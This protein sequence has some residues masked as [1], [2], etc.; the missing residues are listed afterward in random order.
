MITTGFDLIERGANPM[1]MERDIHRAVDKIITTLSTMKEDVDDKKIFQVATVSAHGDEEIGRLVAKAVKM[2]GRDGV[3]TAEPS[4]TSETYVDQVA[5]IELPKSS[6]LH[7]SFITHPEEVKAELTDCRILLWEGVLGS[8]KSLVPLLKQIKDENA[9]VLIVAGGFEAEALSMLINNKIRLALQ[10][11]VVRLEAYGESRKNLLY[12]IAALTGGRV[13]L[14]ADGMKIDNVKLSDLGMARKVVTTMSNTKIIDGKGKQAD[15]TGRVDGLKRAIEESIEGAERTALRR[16][17][18]ALIG[19]ITIIKVGGVTVTEME[20]KKDRVVD[21]MSAAKAAI[22]SGIVA[23][24]GTALFRARVSLNQS[25]GTGFEVVRE[26]CTAVVKQIATNA[27]AEPKEIVKRLDSTMASHSNP[28]FSTL[29]AVGY[30]AYSDS[31]EDLVVTGV[32]DPVKVVIE[33]LRNAAAVACSILTMG[34]VISEIKG[35]TTNV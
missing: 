27:G 11:N 6:L 1:S 12:D 16:R 20:E 31:F 24:G 17:L 30:N 9:P 14:E 7:Q 35:P 34:A 25:E 4:T 22:E 15:L 21:A 33:S 18:A 13:F 19:G 32:I 23:G 28:K 2:A 10:L 8:A 29:S 5:G 3:V 26:A